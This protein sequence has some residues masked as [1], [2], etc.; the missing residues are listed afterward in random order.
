MFGGKLYGSLSKS[1]N[2]D[3]EIMSEHYVIFTILLLDR[4]V[5]FWTMI[6]KWAAH[7]DARVIENWYICGH[8]RGVVC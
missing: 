5:R 6:A 4:H 8:V 1:D 3:L 2:T 7:I